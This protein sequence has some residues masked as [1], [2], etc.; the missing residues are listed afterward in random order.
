MPNYRFRV[1]EA[2]NLVLQVDYQKPANPYNF[3]SGR[4]WR[5]ATV[6]DIPVTNPFDVPRDRQC[7]DGGRNA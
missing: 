2:G 7:F 4:D 5:D 3:D 6:E 1:N